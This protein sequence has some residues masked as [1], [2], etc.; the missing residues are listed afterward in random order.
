MLP[1]RQ[2]LSHEEFL[3]FWR[4]VH[5]PLTMALPGLRRCVMSEVVA[6]PGGELPCDAMVE[7]WWDTIEAVRDAI[8]SP[9]ARACEQ[10]LEHFVDLP[11]WKV[12]LSRELDA[13]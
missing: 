12:F 13:S 5:L 4:S 11:R 6:A 10:S 8:G 3:D 9:Q 2:D 1:R 7:L